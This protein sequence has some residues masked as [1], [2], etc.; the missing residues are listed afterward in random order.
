MFQPYQNF[1]A[2]LVPKIDGP[3]RIAQGKLLLPQEARRKTSV[4]RVMWVG[5]GKKNK[6]GILAV[7]EVEQG[8][9][10]VYRKY[11]GSDLEL[12]GASLL[13]VRADDILAVIERSGKSAISSS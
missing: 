2:L 4:G 11:A 9:E 5:T 12:D 13:F 6:R 1:V 8:Q 3:E 7:P 10:V